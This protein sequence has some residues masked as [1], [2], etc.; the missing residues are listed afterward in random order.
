MGEL[1]ELEKRVLAELG[2]FR[3]E[4][5]AALTNATVAG[6]GTSD[7]FTAVRLAFESLVEAGLAIVG[8]DSAYPSR[9][10]RLSKADSLTLLADIGSH[11]LF[12]SELGRWTGGR[13]PWPELAV[14]EAGLV[15]ANRIL[16]ERGERWWRR[17]N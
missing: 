11:L 5:F 15:E 7:E 2:E 6:S 17:S 4:N 14:T 8:V 10:D 16:A 13:E 12:K 1:S 9:L 3:R